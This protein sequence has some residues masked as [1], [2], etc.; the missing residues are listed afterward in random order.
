MGI[1]FEKVWV[2]TLD[3]RTRKDH[4]KLDGQM[5]TKTVISIL[6]DLKLNHLEISV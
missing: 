6:V 3:S 1:E 4:Q 5:Q 2:S